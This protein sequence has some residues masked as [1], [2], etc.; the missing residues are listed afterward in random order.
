MCVQPSLCL[1]GQAVS[2]NT[3]RRG[4]LLDVINS[5]DNVCLRDFPFLSVDCDSKNSIEL[6]NI[7]KANGIMGL[8][9]VISRAILDKINPR[10]IDQYFAFSFD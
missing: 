7:L 4:E 10:A 8:S 6:L 1:L 5:E 3:K 9:P 2:S